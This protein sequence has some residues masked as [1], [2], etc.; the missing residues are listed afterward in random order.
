VYNRII[1]VS[2]NLFMKKSQVT[3]LLL[4]ILVTSSL[5]SLLFCWL[6]IHT[7]L[8]LREIQR[9][10]V[11]PQAYRTT[12]IA[13]VKDVMDYSDK[14]PTINPILEAAGFKAPRT[15]ILAP[16]NKPAGK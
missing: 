12:F 8:R 1:N 13:L 9:S 6:Y 11:N 16:A 10:M 7:A 2:A 5:V 15:S 4:A 3:N 14:D